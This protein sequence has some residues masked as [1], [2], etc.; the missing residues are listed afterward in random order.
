MLDEMCRFMLDF[1]FIVSLQTSIPKSPP[2]RSDY[3]TP[4]DK[5]AMELGPPAMR[6]LPPPTAVMEDQPSNEKSTL[7]AVEMKVAD[8]TS[9]STSLSDDEESSEIPLRS[10]DNVSPTASYWH[11][12]LETVMLDILWVVSLFACA[13]Q[14]FDV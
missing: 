8:V 12:P 1:T 13:F 6:S 11:A 4:T 10:A 7:E 2:K 5:F 14:A 9:T 3:K